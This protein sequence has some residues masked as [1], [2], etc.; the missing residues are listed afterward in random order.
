MSRCPG[1]GSRDAALLS[2][3]SSWAFQAVQGPVDTVPD[4]FPGPT[5][6]LQDYTGYFHD[7]FRVGNT[8]LRTCQP[9]RK[10]RGIFT[11]RCRRLGTWRL[12]WAGAEALTCHSIKLGLVALNFLRTTHQRMTK[13]PICVHVYVH[14]Y[15]HI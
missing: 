11:L 4:D 2:E 5:H 10:R 14:I 1:H 12:N 13:N 6:G 9:F 15:I 8:G 7:Q 3:H